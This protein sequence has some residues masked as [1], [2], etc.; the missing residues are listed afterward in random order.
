[1]EIVGKKKYKFML[2]S[3]VSFAKACDRYKMLELCMES[4][5]GTRNVEVLN[6]LMKKIMANENNT[7][8][9]LQLFQ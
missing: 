1:M 3:T 5:F 7:N 8:D 4:M 6:S 9:I 2:I